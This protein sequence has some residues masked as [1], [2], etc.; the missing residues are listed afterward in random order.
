MSKTFAVL[1]GNTIT[2]TII[3]DTLETAE[4]VTNSAC[5]EYTADKP[6]G[7]GWTYDGTN[8][9]APEVLE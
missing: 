4:A 3:A 7:I 2:N 6:A 1:N 5:V 9:I 8:F